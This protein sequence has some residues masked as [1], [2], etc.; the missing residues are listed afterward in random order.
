[1]RKIKAQTVEAYHHNHDFS[2]YL[3][4]LWTGDLDRL[5][6]VFSLWTAVT[7]VKSPLDALTYIFEKSDLEHSISQS[8]PAEVFYLPYF[9]MI[10]SACGHELVAME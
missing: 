3:G 7:L 1:M 4:T 6:H 10:R 5:R 8:S 9:V 2:E